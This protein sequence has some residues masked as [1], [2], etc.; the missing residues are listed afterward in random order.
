MC[1]SVSEARDEVPEGDFRT[2]SR[3]MRGITCVSTPTP[4]VS[5]S[6]AACCAC[7]G[8]LRSRDEMTF[9]LLAKKIS[10]PRTTAGLW[11]SPQA[12]HQILLGAKIRASDFFHELLTG[13]TAPT[14]GQR[15]FVFSF[16]MIK[17]SLFL[18]RDA[19]FTRN[20][21]HWR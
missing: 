15:L 5:S 17:S 13:Q 2:S 9:F 18:S 14:A 3:P 20:R 6:R 19:S 10:A 11:I 4:F 21:W 16:P 12:G 1:V 7:D 8:W